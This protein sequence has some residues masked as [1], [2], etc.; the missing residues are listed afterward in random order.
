MSA[1][2]IWT[3]FSVMEQHGGGFCAALALA[4]RKADGANKARIEGAFPHLLEQFGPE[5][6]YYQHNPEAA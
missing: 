3:T 6:R 1:L 4:W 5:S 2:E